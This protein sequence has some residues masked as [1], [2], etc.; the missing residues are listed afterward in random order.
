MIQITKPTG[1]GAIARLAASESYFG[2]E[3]VNVL[4]HIISINNGPGIMKIIYSQNLPK[5]DNKIL[6]HRKYLTNR[7]SFDVRGD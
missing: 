7:L 5:Y 2:T 6:N 4:F 3:I 1:D